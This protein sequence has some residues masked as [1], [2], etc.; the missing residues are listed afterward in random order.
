MF[1]QQAHISHWLLIVIIIALFNFAA[2]A[3]KP[4]FAPRVRLSDG[5]SIPVLGLGT[6]WAKQPEGEQAIKDAIDIGY[7]HIDTAY[8]YGNEK[9]V[10]NAIRTKIAEGVIKREDIFVTTKLWNT[11]HEPDSVAKAFQKSLDNLNITYVD[12][13]LMHSPVS[14]QRISQATNMTTQDFDNIILFPQDANGKSLCTD[15]DYLGT[16]KAMEELVKTGKVRSLGVSNFNSQQLDRVITAAKIKPVVN[17]IECHPNFNQKKFIAFAKA[18]NVT[19][20]GYSPLGRPYANGD[21]P[22][23]LKNAQVQ[24]LAAKY[25]KNPGQILLRYSYQNG[26]VVIP[27]ST[28]KERIRGN[29]DIFDFNLNDED[30][31]FMDS[32]NGNSRF[33]TILDRDGDNK[34]YPFNIEF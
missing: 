17:E 19:I 12:L 26:V 7:R 33:T 21:R 30:M 23:A 5:N 10:G 24:A 29:I 1:Y 15:I 18:R 32:L 13:Y 8:V 9:E 20:I 28:N 4:L 3:E 27:K 31:E 16:W 11:F 25:K 6:S 14:Y 22:I 34:Y 2:S